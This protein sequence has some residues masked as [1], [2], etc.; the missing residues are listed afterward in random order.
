[1]ISDTAVSHHQ[2]SDKSCQKHHATNDHTRERN[3]KRRTACE[4]SR[5]N[6]M[7]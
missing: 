4:Q 2:L 1:M 5:G 7:H 6:M 3:I